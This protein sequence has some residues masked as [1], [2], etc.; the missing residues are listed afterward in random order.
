M[1]T[2][3]T[4]TESGDFNRSN[5]TTNI[6]Y[7][8]DKD[9][10]VKESNQVRSFKSPAWNQSRDLTSLLLTNRLTA[11]NNNNNVS[12]DMFTTQP[13]IVQPHLISTSNDALAMSNINSSWILPSQVNPYSNN[14]SNNNLKQIKFEEPWGHH[15]RKNVSNNS[16]V[17]PSN[18]SEYDFKQDVPL[19]IGACI[20]LILFACFM[21]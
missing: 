14:R 10:A 17:F 9:M 15:Y 7:Y 12:R 2:I 11:Y 13:T 4:I 21:I 5:E 19:L 8:E 20:G 18:A 1:V 16:V 3:S 6:P